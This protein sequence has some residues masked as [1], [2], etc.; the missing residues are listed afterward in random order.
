MMKVYQDISIEY[1]IT[2]KFS[3]SCTTP[4][5]L[6]YIDVYVTGSNKLEPLVFRNQYTEI[7]ICNSQDSCNEKKDKFTLKYDNGL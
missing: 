4:L 6:K 2:E 3:N 1:G 5:Y 7:E